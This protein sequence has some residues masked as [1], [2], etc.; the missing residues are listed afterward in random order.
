MP[1]DALAA[2][3]PI[4]GSEDADGNTILGSLALNDNSSVTKSYGTATGDR[5]LALLY[6]VEGCTLPPGTT[7]APEQVSILPANCFSRMQDPDGLRS[8]AGGARCSSA[9]AISESTSTRSLRRRER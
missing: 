5:R 6:E 8:P 4:C 9:T 7:I 1:A 2:K 3:I